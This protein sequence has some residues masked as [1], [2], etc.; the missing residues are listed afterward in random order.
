MQSKMLES[1]ITNE[2]ETEKIRFEIDANDRCKF[3]ILT[4]TLARNVLSRASPIEISKHFD[5][6]KQRFASI[7][8]CDVLLY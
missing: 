3:Q 4:A 1:S 5:W 6:C 8:L 7:R 2:E